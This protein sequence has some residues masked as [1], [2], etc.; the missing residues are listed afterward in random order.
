VP[1]I[2]VDA[3]HLYGV[4]I[5]GVIPRWLPVLWIAAPLVGVPGLILESSADFLTTPATVIFG[6]AFMGTGYALW[7][8]RSAV[9]I[10]VETIMKKRWCLTVG[11]GF[12]TSATTT[13]MEAYY[14]TT[15]GYR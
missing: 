8:L 11:Y 12:Y 13:M 15:T 1:G 10:E 14:V 3:G 9:G 2:C 5:T 4:A 6:L 7:K